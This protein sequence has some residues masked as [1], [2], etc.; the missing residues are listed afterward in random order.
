[1][2]LAW[3][4]FQKYEAPE[5]TQEGINNF[6][7]FITDDVLRKMFLKGEY[8]LFVALD[9]AVIVGIISLRN[10]N[11]ISLLFV[12]EAYHRQGIGRGLIECLREYMYREMGQI[13]ITVNAAPYA[14]AFYHKIGFKDRA[15]RM[16]KDG[17][18]FTPMELVI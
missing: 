4:V 2:N 5:Y 15:G 18:T 12:D 13:I 11:H 8:Q 6:R 9:G 17:I 10:F 14:E 1:M 16:T 3:K 7:D